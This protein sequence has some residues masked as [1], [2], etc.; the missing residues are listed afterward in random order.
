L[1]LFTASMISTIPF[2]S[3]RG[4]FVESEGISVGA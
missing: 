1:T 2:S 3:N 4:I